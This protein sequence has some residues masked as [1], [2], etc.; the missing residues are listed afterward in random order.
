M[1]VKRLLR[2]LTPLLHAASA[3]CGCGPAADPVGARVNTISKVVQHDSALPQSSVAVVVF[4]GPSVSPTLR[5]D[6]VQFIL[7]C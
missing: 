7:I 3:G 1:N 5:P 2:G 6:Q 4:D